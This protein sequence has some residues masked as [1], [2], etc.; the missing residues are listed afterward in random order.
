[1]IGAMTYDEALEHFG[2]TQEKLAAALG[3]TQPTVSVWKGV[4]PDAYQYQ[5]EVITGGKLR[6]DPEL[7]RP[8]NAVSQQAAAANLREQMR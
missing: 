3:I 5:I 7:R 1:M 8:A 6:A 4:L 2:G